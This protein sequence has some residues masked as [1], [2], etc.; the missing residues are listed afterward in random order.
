[1][2]R[3]K[4]SK[5]SKWKH[6]DS[7]RHANVYT[8]RMKVDGGYLYLVTKMINPKKPSAGASVHGLVF[9]PSTYR[10]VNKGVVVEKVR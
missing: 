6:V 2:R 5:A 10:V 9:V 4:T 7:A 3:R 1:M 8:D